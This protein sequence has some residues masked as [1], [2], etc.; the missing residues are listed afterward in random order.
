MWG[1]E[2]EK[3]ASLEL[4]D[5]PP[6]PPIPS[7]LPL[8]HITAV[9]ISEAPSTSP[10]DQPKG[11]YL[12]LC[13]CYGSIREKGQILMHVTINSIEI[14]SNRWAMRGLFCTMRPF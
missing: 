13:P 6:K 7:P 12:F 10:G 5:S 1:C 8:T 3:N 11:P 14:A 2:W 9:P 4:H